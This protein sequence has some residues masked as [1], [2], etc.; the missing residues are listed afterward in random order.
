[1]LGLERSVWPVEETGVTTS[2]QL[3]AWPA[4]RHGKSRPT[5]RY[6]LRGQEWILE[7]R[8]LAHPQRCCLYALCA[9]HCGRVWPKCGPSLARQALRHRKSRPTRRHKLRGQEWLT[10]VRSLAH[11]QRCCLYA[12]CALHCG[13]VWPKCGPS[14][15]RRRLCVAQVARLEKPELALAA[16]SLCGAVRRRRCVWPGVGP[17]HNFLSYRQASS[18]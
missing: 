6:K 14:S 8:S 2:T 5:Q 9:L 18:S 17:E 11:P 15:A 1:M 4:E 3:L 7:V 10:E 12:L 13:R 16:A